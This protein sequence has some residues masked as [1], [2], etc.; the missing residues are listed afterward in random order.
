MALKAVCHGVGQQGEELI[1]R[2][3]VE[4]ELSVLLEVALQ[5]DSTCE[6]YLLARRSEQNFYAEYVSR[7]VSLE[8]ERSIAHRQG[9]V[10]MEGRLLADAVFDAAQMLV[11]A[12]PSPTTSP[13]TSLVGDYEVDQEG[14]RTEAPSTSSAEQG[15]R[16][17]AQ[18]TQVPQAKSAA[19][20]GPPASAWTKLVAQQFTEL[21]NVTPLAQLDSAVATAPVTTGEANVAPQPPARPRSPRVSKLACA[22]GASHEVCAAAE[23]EAVEIWRP[24]GRLAPG[25]GAAS[26]HSGDAG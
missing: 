19:T 5:L 25:R 21:D 22:A 18:R 20:Q 11:W 17:G 15:H 7:E 26:A 6:L 13:A 8:H 16:T 10:V 9:R 14:D 4:G 24:S 1:G 3:T 2:W 12:R 23:S